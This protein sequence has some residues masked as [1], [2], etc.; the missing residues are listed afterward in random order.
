MREININVYNRL[1]LFVNKMDYLS[2]TFNIDKMY[3]N[4][5]LDLI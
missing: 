4:K 1:Y 3:S 5:D 2:D